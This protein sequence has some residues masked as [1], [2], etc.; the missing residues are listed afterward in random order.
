MGVTANCNATA[1]GDRILQHR[2]PL[3]TRPPAPPTAFPLTDAAT[4]HVGALIVNG[5]ASF[6]TIADEVIE[7]VARH[8]SSAKKLDPRLRDAIDAHLD[9]DPAE[10]DSDAEAECS[11]EE[12]EAWRGRMYARGNVER[13]TTG[14]RYTIA[15]T[16][17]MIGAMLRRPE[18]TNEY[19]RL[20]DAGLEPA[21]ALAAV[22]NQR[23]QAKAR[24]AHQWNGGAL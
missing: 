14:T 13:A 5:N 15:E 6:R 17:E 9:H 10:G 18:E 4:Q 8:I 20:R 23:K 21:D 19:N 11:V 22:L 1:A 7:M 2:I 24:N 3:P 12:I 16:S